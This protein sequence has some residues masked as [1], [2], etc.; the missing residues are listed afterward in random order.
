MKKVVI[1]EFDRTYYKQNL[2]KIKERKRKYREQNLEKEKEQKRRWLEQ[3]REKKR[4]QDRKWYKQN[5]EKAAEMSVRRHLIARK[6]II[7]PPEPLV[8]LATEIRL[9]KR[10]V[11][12]LTK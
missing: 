5:P 8:K 9:T 4:E 2:E 10:L 6:G 3:N 12:E 1:K 11:K 7:N